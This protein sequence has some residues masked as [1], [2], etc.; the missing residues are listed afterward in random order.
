MA[1]ENTAENTAKLKLVHLLYIL[2]L[3]I[4][5][6]G[7]SLGKTATRQEVNTETIEAH[8]TDKVDTKVFEM[9]QQQQIREYTDIKDSLKRIEAK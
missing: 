7:Y 4:L 1:K 3:A 8:K 2:I 9:H 6:A 5:A